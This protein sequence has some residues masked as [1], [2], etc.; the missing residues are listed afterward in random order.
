MGMRM[1]PRDE[2]TKTRRKKPYQMFVRWNSTPTPVDVWP[3]C[4]LQLTLYAM[5]RRTATQLMEH[6]F[7]SAAL[8]TEIGPRAAKKFNKTIRYYRRYFR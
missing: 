7:V 1:N 2:I 3:T 6:P 5:G 4:R 8:A